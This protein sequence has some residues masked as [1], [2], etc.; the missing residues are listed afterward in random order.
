MTVITGRLAPA[1]LAFAA[2]VATPAARPIRA[3]PESLARAS[4][5]L[6]RNLEADAYT[7][8]RF[9][10]RPWIARVCEAFAD[11]PDMPI[12]RL[13]GDAHVGQFAITSDAWGLDDFDDSARGP[14]VID[15]VRF[16]GSID[17][18]A[19]HRGWTKERTALFTRFLD[20]YRRGLSDPDYR[21][22]QPEVVHRLQAQPA[23]TRESF[24]QWGESQMQQM[25]DAELAAVIQG[26][27]AFSDLIRR[28]HDDL[29][30]EYFRVVRAGWLHMGVGSAEELKVLLRIEG[31]SA[32]PADDELIEA[33]RL[34]SLDG[35][36]C[37]EEPPSPQTARVIIG[38]HQMGRLKHRILSPGPDLVIPELLVVG[39][40]LGD[41]WIRSW[42]PSYREIR[43]DD[44]HSVQD[45]AE[46][47]YDSGTQLG[48]GSL[49]EVTGPEA[50]TVRRR[51]LAS[52]KALEPRLRRQTVE[53][54][55]DLLKGWREL[56]SR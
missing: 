28:D 56:R 2:V 5:E 8:F 24:L 33:K 10:N 32:D 51:Q 46:V 23:V 19:R 12:V 25:T 3:E 44:F 9:V 36:T 30:P 1:I 49:H 38:S 14:A 34:G 18:V 6:R 52:M 26:M 37:L 39:T 50:D 54:V 16:L 48:A 40:S 21:A 31:P 35:L 22:P 15:I 43:L 41:W 20:G 29:P 45:L 53:L 13:H 11:V 27:K 7:Y 47:I 4:P 55:D 17:L 42:D